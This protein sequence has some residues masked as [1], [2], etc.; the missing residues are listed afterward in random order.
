ML[1]YHFTNDTRTEDLKDNLMSV[2]NHIENNTWE[3]TKQ[4]LD[5]ARNG[6]YHIYTLYFGLFKGSNNNQ[7][8]LNQ[9]VNE[10]IT[11]FLKKFQF[12][13]PRAIKGT[14]AMKDEVDNGQQLAPLRHLVKLLFYKAL[15]EDSNQASISKED[16]IRYI[17][18]NDQV[19]RNEI[20]VQ[21]SYEQLTNNTLATVIQDYNYYGGDKGRFVTQL[22]NI[23]SV[24]PFIEFDKTNITLFI[25]DLSDTSKRQLLDIISYNDFWYPIQDAEL[26]QNAES[27]KTYMEVPSQGEHPV[28]FEVSQPTLPSEDF[29]SAHNVIYYGAPGTG[30]SYS[31]TERIK[32]IYPNFKVKNT[33]DSRNVFRTTLHPEYAYN[34]FVG[35]IMPTVNE[36]GTEYKFTPGV[37]TLALKR[38]LHLEEAGH[39]VFLVLEEL[40]RANVAAVFGDLFQLLDRDEGK[41]EY[42]VSNPLIAKEIYDL[43][44]T[45]IKNNIVD[46]NIY[47]PSNLYIYGTVNTNDQNVFVMDTAFKRRFD[48]SYVSTKP[49]S[50]LNNPQLVIINM[51][52]EVRS[53]HW[54]DLYQQLNDF[55]TREMKLGEDKQVG[56]F[57]IKF[58]H[59]EIQNKL[60]FQNKL[61]QY[62]W[63]DVESSSFNG[64]KLFDSAIASYSDLYEK[65]GNDER[66]FGAEFLNNLL[67]FITPLSA[68]KNNQVAEEGVDYISDDRIDQ[69]DE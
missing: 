60:M 45:D 48:W 23:V 44:D 65:F 61:L 25:E 51:Q 55:I 28:S 15:G 19:A 9:E 21:Q 46:T 66:I 38:A 1:T 54:H 59:S 63:D 11:Q 62:L 49:M 56:Q 6:W 17:L 13:N 42:A 5:K 39:P 12:P 43:S 64:R 34:D 58:G 14:P 41:S 40:S 26:A 20:T 50:G 53:I 2:A 7:L 68:Y 4:S 22:L 67:S 24:L 16:F 47:L 52:G 27:Y 3:N 10:V 36:D 29:E 35:Q 57:F 32:A 8:I 69:T 31:V 37:F 30:K 18:L 33:P